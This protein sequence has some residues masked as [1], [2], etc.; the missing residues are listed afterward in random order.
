MD[1][2]NRGG[3]IRAFRVTKDDYIGKTVA[4]MEAGA[5][6]READKGLPTLIEKIIRDGEIFYVKPGCGLDNDQPG[7]REFTFEIGFRYFL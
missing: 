1:L 4:D 5:A 2:G 3:S 7:D 6:K